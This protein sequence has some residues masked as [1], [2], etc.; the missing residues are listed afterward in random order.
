MTRFSEDEAVV[1]FAR[2]LKGMGVEE[3]LERMGAKRGDLVQ[4]CDYMFEFKE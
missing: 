3:E 4:I 1:R 2:K